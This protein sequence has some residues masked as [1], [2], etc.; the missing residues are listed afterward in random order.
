L[1]FPGKRSSQAF[2]KLEKA[3]IDLGVWP[4]TYKRRISG[5]STA[6]AGCLRGFGRFSWIHVFFELSR[7]TVAPRSSAREE[8]T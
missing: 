2:F 8:R 5:S 4:A 1:Y 3:K 6:L 7:R